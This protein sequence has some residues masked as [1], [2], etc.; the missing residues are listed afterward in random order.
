MRC[1]PEAGRIRLKRAI[2][3]ITIISV[4]VPGVIAQS[5]LDEIKRKD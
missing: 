4:F 1:G 3:L 5:P 2:V